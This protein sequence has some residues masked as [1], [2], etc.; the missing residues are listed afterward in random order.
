[1]S[2]V[3]KSKMTKGRKGANEPQKS[4]NHKEVDDD[5][6]AHDADHLLA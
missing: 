4:E 2:H 3:L 1:M 5:N 6:E